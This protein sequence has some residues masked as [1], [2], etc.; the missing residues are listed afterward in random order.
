LEHVEG[1]HRVP[2]VRGANAYLLTFGPLTLVDCGLPGSGRAVIEFMAA[3]GHRP[4][5]LERILI[6]HRHPD[7]CGGAAYLRDRTGA[8][9]C[10]HGGDALV[11]GE[12]SVLRGTVR[13]GGVIVDR[14]LEDGAE[15]PGGIRVVHCGGHT[16]GSACY[17][18][19]ERGLLFLGD[20]AINNVDRLSRPISF[21]NEDSAAYERALARLTQLDAEAGFFGHGP[22]LIGGL[23]EALVALE[24]RGPTPA[25]RGI[26]RFALMR[27]RH[28]FGRRD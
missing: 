11:A 22:P 18:V 9:V 26:L 2:G 7:H 20:M 27:L 4:E 1:V 23:R 8:E 25:W 6:T 10:A 3:L 12:L 15:L 21:S 24:E 19:P 14:L 28:P 16:A 5:A 17:Y 13:A